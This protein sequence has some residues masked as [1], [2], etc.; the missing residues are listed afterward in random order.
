MTSLRKYHLTSCKLTNFL[1]EINLGTCHTIGVPKV[2][3]PAESQSNVVAIQNKC[4]TKQAEKPCDREGAPLGGL[5]RP[6]WVS[7]REL[8]CHYK[9]SGSHPHQN[10]CP[11]TNGHTLLCF[12]FTCCPSWALLDKPQSQSGSRLFLPTGSH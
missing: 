11:Q 9:N 12:L 5:S 6:A 1:S 7:A 3:R 8:R 10:F 2:A 4:R